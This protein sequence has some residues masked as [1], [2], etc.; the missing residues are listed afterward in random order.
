VKIIKAFFA[1]LGENLKHKY[2]EV[3]KQGILK[4]AKLK[5]LNN[6]YGEAIETLQLGFNLE[7]IKC[8][9]DSDF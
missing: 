9:F 8:H 6:R 5:F 2:P 4:K 3:F 1:G 7:S